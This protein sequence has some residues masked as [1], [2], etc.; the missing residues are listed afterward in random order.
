MSHAGPAASESD[1]IIVELFI[2]VSTCDLSVAVVSKQVV[3]YMAEL[4]V[5]FILTESCC[6]F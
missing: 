4:I 3:P 6:S 2:S 1:P 5:S